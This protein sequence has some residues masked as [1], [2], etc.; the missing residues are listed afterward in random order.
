MK[1]IAEGKA[2]PD[3][4]QRQPDTYSGAGEMNHEYWSQPGT[5][6][7]RKSAIREHEQNYRGNEGDQFSQE[8]GSGRLVG[9]GHTL[10][11]FSSG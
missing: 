5:H 7:N 10:S 11:P 1:L 2:Q 3:E 8:S 6:G 9:L 4:G